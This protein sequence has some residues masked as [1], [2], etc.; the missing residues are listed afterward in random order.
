MSISADAKLISKT[1][2]GLREF[3]F[4]VFNYNAKT[5]K[6]RGGMKGWVDLCVIGKTGIHLIEVKLDNTKDKFK[7][8]QKKLGEMISKLNKETDLINYWV[9]HN[10][11][12][13]YAIFDY[14]LNPM[15]E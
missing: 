10:L 3:N 6:N 2:A 12:E 4:L 8:A 15:K 13:A 1:F 11:E 5:M 7:P 9:I 14:I